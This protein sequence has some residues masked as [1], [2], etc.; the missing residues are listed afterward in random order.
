MIHHTAPRV[1]APRIRDAVHP[2]VLLAGLALVA[3]SAGCQGGD[4]KPVAQGT[5]KWAGS[6]KTQEELQEARRLAQENLEQ[7][8][9]ALKQPAEG[10]RGF[11]VKKKF[12]DEQRNEGSA[13]G[14]DA[15]V[16]VEYMWVA[17][18][19]YTEDGGFRGPVDNQPQ[20]LDKPE[21]GEVVTVAANEVEDWV[22]LDNGQRQGGWSIDVLLK[23][24]EEE[25][26]TT[27]EQ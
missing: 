6:E 19:E 9:Q 7:F 17:V 16:D 11:A 2:I 4:A 14:Q 20:V 27:A 13:P 15:V 23:P 26:S 8:I 10:Q 3:A 5:L 12:T 21:K 25:S 18:T 24:T 1:P 22:Y